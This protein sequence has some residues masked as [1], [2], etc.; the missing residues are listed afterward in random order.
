VRRN[1][2]YPERVKPDARADD[3]DDRIDRADLMEMHVLDRLAV[4]LS[5]GLGKGRK[6]GECGI[7]DGRRKG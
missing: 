4:G 5:L 2:L 6:D 1:L 3:V 7:A